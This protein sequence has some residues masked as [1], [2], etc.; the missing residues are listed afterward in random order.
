MKATWGRQ[1]LFASQFQVIV[2]L[3]GEVE[4]AG[5]ETA[6]HGHIRVQDPARKMVTLTFRASPLTSAKTIHCKP[7]PSPSQSRQALHET[8]L[9]G[10]STLYQ[11]DVDD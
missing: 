11:V 5:T 4:A 9:P 8:F 6:S 7:T 10:N 1:G 2:H 3:C